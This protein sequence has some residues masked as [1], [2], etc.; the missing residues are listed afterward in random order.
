[1]TTVLPTSLQYCRYTTLQ[2]AKVVVLIV[3]PFTTMNNRS[4]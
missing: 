3:W 4:G 1:M 2:N